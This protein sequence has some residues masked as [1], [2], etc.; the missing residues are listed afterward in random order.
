M[1]SM[2]TLEDEYMNHTSQMILFG[3]EKRNN[4]YTHTLYI[5]TKRGERE[6]GERESEAKR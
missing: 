6:G 2:H 3:Q 4:N 1:F 5:K